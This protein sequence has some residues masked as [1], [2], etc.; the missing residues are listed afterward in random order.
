MSNLIMCRTSLA[1]REIIE[2]IC[3]CVMLCLSMV[4]Y[5]HAAHAEDCMPLQISLLPSVQLVSKENTICGARLNLLWG[6]NTSVT[7]IDAGLANVTGSLKGIEIGGLNWL[8]NSAKEESW[9]VQLAGINYVGDSSFSGVQV[10]FLNGGSSKA[11]M[12]GIQAGVMNIW[13]GEINGIQLGGINGG[14]NAK[15]LQIAVYNDARDI[16]G[17][18]IGFF[19]GSEGTVHGMQ[20]GL[21]NYCKSLSGVQIGLI[22]FVTSR[23]PDKGL[24]ASPFINVGF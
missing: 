4:L 17:L 12:A 2:N 23:F 10:G 8:S 15:G 7:G 9:G 14:S 24:F 5:S 21:G 18:Q 1:Y 13:E 16:T 22:N 20:I 11:S 3:F 19:N 6:E